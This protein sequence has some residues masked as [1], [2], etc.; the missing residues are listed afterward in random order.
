MQG[1][2]DVLTQIMPFM[3]THRHERHHYRNQ[4]AWLFIIVTNKADI[5]QVEYNKR[6]HVNGAE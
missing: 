4:L 3:I 1:S 5:K 2:G 6:K